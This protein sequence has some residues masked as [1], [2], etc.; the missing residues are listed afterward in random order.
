MERLKRIEEELKDLEKEKR[1]RRLEGFL[2]ELMKGGDQHIKEY[3]RDVGAGKEK[4]E[5][6]RDNRSRWK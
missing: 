4:R 3:S 1:I 6:E 2:V 5:A